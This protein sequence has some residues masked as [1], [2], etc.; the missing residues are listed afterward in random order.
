MAMDVDLDLRDRVTELEGFTSR[1]VLAGDDRDG[2]GWLYNHLETRLLQER[3]F[4]Q[5][6]VAIALASM[7]DHIV[8]LCKTTIDAML[9][10]TI[11]GTFDAKAAY[12]ACDVV[13]CNGASFIARRDNPGVCPGAG[14]GGQDSVRSVAGCPDHRRRRAR[15]RGERMDWG[16]RAKGYAT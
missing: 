9:S 8:D 2:W 11:R 5:E 13:A 1:L 4:S 6:V 7:R 15:L 3:K 12:S 14:R 10:K 16:R